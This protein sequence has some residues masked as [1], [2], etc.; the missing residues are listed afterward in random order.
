PVLDATRQM[1]GDNADVNDVFHA[2][3]TLRVPLDYLAQIFAAGDADMVA[4]VLMKLAAVR[5]H[6]RALTAGGADVDNMDAADLE[7]L[8]RLLAIAKIDQRF[9]IPKAHREDAAQLAS[10]VA[11]CPLDYPDGVG[12]HPDGRELSAVVSAR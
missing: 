3:S 6:M 10:W 2:V 8:Y 1:G 12:M 11:G 7:E 9:V 4:G 5:A